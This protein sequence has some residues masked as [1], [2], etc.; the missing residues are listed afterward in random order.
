M[1][2]RDIRRRCLSEHM[3]LHAVLQGNKVYHGSNFGH[4]HTK[5]QKSGQ[6]YRTY[7]SGDIPADEQRRLKVSV[8][9]GDRRRRGDPSLWR[10]GLAS[11]TS[12]ERRVDGSHA[13]RIVVLN[14]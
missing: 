13:R 7:A 10:N 12:R 4:L 2:P 1:P 14:A 3:K 11:A 5:H 8:D 9:L 6:P